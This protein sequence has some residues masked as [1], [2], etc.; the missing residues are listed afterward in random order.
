M[1]LPGELPECLA[2]VIRGRGF[3]DSKNRI[4]IFGWCRRHV[5]VGLV[6]SKLQK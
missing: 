5:L 6:Q 4:I 1:V 2:D 3:L